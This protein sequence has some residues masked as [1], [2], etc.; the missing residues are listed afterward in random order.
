MIKVSKGSAEDGGHILKNKIHVTKRE[1]EALALIGMGMNNYEVAE[2]MGVSV[3]TVR[4][5]IWNVMQKFGASSRAHAIVLAIQ[6][7]IIDVKHERSLVEFMP[8]DEWYLCVVCGRAS[9]SHEYKDVEPEKVTIN[10]VTYEVDMLPRCPYEGCKGDVTEKLYWD[11]VR[12]HHP[13][14]PEIPERGKVYEYD[15]KWLWPEAGK[16]K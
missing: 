8:G 6:N 10:H 7:S 4:N 12:E 16:E 5:H 1:L 15:I 11:E 2:K 3:N 9:L 14:Y 13:E